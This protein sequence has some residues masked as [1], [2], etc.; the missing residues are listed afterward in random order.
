MN[1]ILPDNPWTKRN[2]PC[3]GIKEGDAEFYQ[4]DWISGAAAVIRRDAIEE[5]GYFDE[6]FF[7]YWED[8]DLCQ[9]MKGAGWDVVYCPNLEV[10]HLVGAH[11]VAVAPKLFLDEG[12]HRS[13]VAREAHG[14]G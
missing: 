5:I 9:R 8:A 2:I 6:R 4:V 12:A 1:R 13:L 7:M 10:T 3:L 14:F 11:L